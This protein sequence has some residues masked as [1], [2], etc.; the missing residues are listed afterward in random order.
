MNRKLLLDYRKSLIFKNANKIN[1]KLSD[2]LYIQGYFLI[3]FTSLSTGL[4]DFKG[5]YSHS[6]H[7]L[8]ARS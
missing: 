7:A 1:N 8:N 5:L 3:I 4:N 2:H 6:L